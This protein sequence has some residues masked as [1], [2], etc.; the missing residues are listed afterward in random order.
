MTGKQQKTPGVSN[1]RCFHRWSL[2]SEFK[3]LMGRD[4][5]NL[6]QLKQNIKG[7]ADLAQFNGAD[8]GAVDVYQFRQL[9]LGIALFLSIVY[10]IQSKLLILFPIFILQIA[11]TPYLC[12]LPTKNRN[13]NRVKIDKCD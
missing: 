8:I 12:I 11:H 13:L 5:Q 3:Q 10:H 4:L 1:A 7:N 6:R 2:L 9:G